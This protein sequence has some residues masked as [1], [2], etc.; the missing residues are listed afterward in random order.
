MNFAGN[1]CLGITLAFLLIGSLRFLV[2]AYRLTNRRPSEWLR[3]KLGRGRRPLELARILGIDLQELK[4]LVPSYKESYIAKKRRGRRRLLI[5]DP[6][7]KKVQRRLLRRLLRRLRAHPAAMGFEAGKSIVH[8]ASAH[9]GQA[10]VIK[11]D[12]VEFFPSIKAT[13]VEAYFRRVGWNAEAA[14]LLTRLSTH[15]NSLPQ[16]A[17]TSPRLSNLVHF[18]FDARLERFVRGRHGAYT[19]YADDITISFPKD[20]PRRVRGTIQ[21]ARRLA[22]HFGVLI[23][24]RGK[25]RI[26]RA[27]Q[28]QRVT[29]L[30]VNHKVHLPKSKRRLLRAIE[31]RLRTGRE[32]TLTETQMKGWRALQE[33]IE[34]QTD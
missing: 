34:T 33:M 17:P 10:V 31:H 16:G 3:V 5:P 25:L 30:V 18:A 21:Y 14:S 23:H 9:V 1:V 4:D 12:V 27:H 19:R 22:K 15:E 29:G 2:K 11:M 32:A 13:I 24:V 8:N 26:L 7:L 28:Q 6:T 20:Y